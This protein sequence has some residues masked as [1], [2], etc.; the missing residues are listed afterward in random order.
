MEKKKKRENIILCST[1]LLNADFKA[2][3][4]PIYFIIACSPG[5]RVSS[6]G[7]F[8]RQFDRIGFHD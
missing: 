3:F 7:N 5:E 6:L 1:K 4:T 8:L 2:K